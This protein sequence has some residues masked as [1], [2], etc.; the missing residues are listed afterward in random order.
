[1]EYSGLNHMN[2]SRFIVENFAPP[3]I[4]GFDADVIFPN[5]PEQQ[6]H[7]V[8]NWLATEPSSPES[9][10]HNEDGRTRFWAN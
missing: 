9:R 3:S 8:D 6:H 7:G 2:I 10:L 4:L 1:M 5:S